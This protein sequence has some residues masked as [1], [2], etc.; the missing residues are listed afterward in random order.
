MGKNLVGIY[1][2]GSASQRSYVQ[3]ESDLDIQMVVSHELTEESKIEITQALRHDGFPCPATKLE[4]VTYTTD[5]LTSPDQLKYSINLNTGRTISDY[6]SFDYTNDP[7]HW[8]LLD[9]AMADK[10]GI[11]LIGEP[12]VSVFPK[13][14]NGVLLDAMQE[15]LNWFI[16]YYPGEECYRCAC[17]ILYYLEQGELVSKRDGV[18]YIVSNKSF[19]AMAQE[20]LIDLVMA[21]LKT[22]R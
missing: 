8:F 13:I 20:S 2:L 19:S 10:H 14:D 22:Q 15:C 3:G 6:I 18:G 21:K 4:F 5:G 12:F 11:N 1:L 9:I 16:N 17:R 7:R